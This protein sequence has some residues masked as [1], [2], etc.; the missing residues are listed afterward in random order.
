MKRTGASN[1][2]LHGGKAPP[3]LVVRMKKIAKPIIQIIIDEYGREEFLRRLS[4]PYWFQS[5]GCVLGY[6]Y[7]SSGVTTVTTG[8]L[9][10]VIEPQELGIFAAGGKGKASLKTPDEIAKVSKNF[11]LSSQ[12]IEELKRSSRMSAKVDNT[13]VQDGAPLYH[14]AFFGTEDGKWVVIQQGMNTDRKIARRYHWISD[15]VK[16]FVNEP[17]EA[18]LAEEMENEV[19]DIT[20]RTSEKCRK[21]STDLVKDNPNHV[22]REFESL[23]SKGQ[24][25]LREWIPGVQ[26]ENRTIKIMN[27]PKRM[28][29]NALEKSYELQP[30]NYEDLLSTKGIGPA[31]VRGLALISEVIHGDPASRKDPA[32]FSY[33]VGGKDGVPFPINKKHYDHIITHLEDTVYQAEIGKDEKLKALKRLKNITSKN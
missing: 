9:K 19:L 26:N 21:T 14:H 25:S 11:N 30:E 1:L 12:R 15:K 20:A 22:Q 13:A 18:I 17:H 33:A 27:M 16:S 3:W 4:N 10:D 32:K 23:L 31:T 28:N 8:V 5:L 2:P 6:D 29:W 7:H 24:K